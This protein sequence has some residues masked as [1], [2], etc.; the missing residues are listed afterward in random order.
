MSIKLRGDKE[1]TKELT[2]RFGASKMKKI[3]DAALTKGGKKVV[4]ILKQNMT[5]FEDK[6]YSVDEV[7]LSEPMWIGGVRTVKIHWKGPH[8]RFRIIHLNEYGHYDRGGNWV[9]TKGKGV[10][11]KAMVKGRNVYFESVKQDLRRL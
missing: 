8:D 1:L 6:G 5:S 2:K 11:D 7:T 10:I 4:Q 3:T 9:D